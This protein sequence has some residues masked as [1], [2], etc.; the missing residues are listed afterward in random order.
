MR[1]G[2]SVVHH[3]RGVVSTDAEPA[4]APHD[5]ASGPS[6][7]SLAGGV[8]TVASEF[9]RASTRDSGFVP[10]LL[11]GYDPKWRPAPVT[12]VLLPPSPENGPTP[13][14]SPTTI[15]AGREYETCGFPSGPQHGRPIVV[16][17]VGYEY[18]RGRWECV[19]VSCDTNKRRAGDHVY[20]L[21]RD[22]KPRTAKGTTT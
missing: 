17:V 2:R 1:L 20:R 4:A 8:D 11:S 6:I 15:V 12:R 16:R 18:A 19:V 7:A 9:L 21:A 14:W 3:G 13:R 22:L 10:M 5:R